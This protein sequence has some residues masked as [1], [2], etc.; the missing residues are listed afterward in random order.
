MTAA[1]TAPQAILKPHLEVQGRRSLS[2]ELKVSGSKNSALVLM[3][4]SLLTEESL[5]L[6]NVPEVTDIQGMAEILLTLGV[7]VKR[8]PEAMELQANHLNHAEPPHKLVSGLRASFLCIGPLLGRLGQAKVPL[9]GGC[10]I[11]ARPVA[12]HIRGLKALGA[13][14]D[15]QHRVVTTAVRGS[16]KGAAVMLG[17]PSVGATETTLMAGVLAEGTTTIQNAGHRSGHKCDHRNDL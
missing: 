9:P 7:R 2:G 15:D 13:M 12:E 14:V 17:C 10:C 16:L 8:G 1:V 5:Q 4:A 6:H 3:A 11:G